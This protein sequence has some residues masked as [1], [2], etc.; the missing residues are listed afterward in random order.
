M[1][2]KHPGKRMHDRER[3]ETSHTKND[4]IRK[5]LKYTA[6]FHER[7]REQDWTKQYGQKLFNLFVTS[8]QTERAKH[9]S[10]CQY[11]AGIHNNF[12]KPEGHY[13][14][15]TQKLNPSQLKIESTS[16]TLTG[17][18]KS[19]INQNRETNFCTKNLITQ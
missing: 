12:P 9:G 10:T 18:L 2:I 13:M 5:P 3:M 15:V 11:L 6:L 14:Y 16:N 17:L 1:L 7:K 4:G 19:V 8:G